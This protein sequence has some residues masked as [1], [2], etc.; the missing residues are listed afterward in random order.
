MNFLL[1]TNICI[2]LINDS[3]TSVRRRFERELGSGSPI[4]TSS[5]TV[6]ELM[7]GAAKSSQR[8]R[9]ENAVNALLSSLS[10]TLLFDTGDARIAGQVRAKLEKAGTPIGTY[11]LLI[12]GQALSRDLILVTANEREFKRVP[13]LRW[14]NWA[15]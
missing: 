2:A 12:A 15:K 1:D 5:V 7:Y 6:L 14:E 11:D 10:P 4:V 8:E 9:N 3:P 13:G